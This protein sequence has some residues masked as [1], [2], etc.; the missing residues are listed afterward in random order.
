MYLR[1]LLS[2]NR[3]L[4]M[5]PISLIFSVLPFLLHLL[6]C[7]LSPSIAPSLLLLFYIQTFLLFNFLYFSSLIVSSRR[8]LLK[9][10]HPKPR[11]Q[12][13]LYSKFYIM[14]FKKTLVA[15]DLL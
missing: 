15:M 1:L 14:Y 6:L 12:E 11:P 10:Q 8:F 4:S 7:L 9:Y 13:S 2:I 5:S 3:I